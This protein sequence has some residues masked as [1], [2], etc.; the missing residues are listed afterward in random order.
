[1][2]FRSFASIANYLEQHGWTADQ[3]WGVEVRIPPTEAGGI[4]ESVGKRDGTCRA[5]RDMSA[6]VP[7]ARWQQLGV[8]LP[9]SASKSGSTTAALVSGT[10]RHFLV[11]PNYDALL[12]YNCAHSYAVSVG[13]LADRIGTGVPRAK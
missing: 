2:L 5:T 7:L 12:A 11:Y 9:P 13:L 6:V 1:M 4:M 3:P 8:R 10:S